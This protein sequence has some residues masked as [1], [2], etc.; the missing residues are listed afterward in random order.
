MPNSSL[1]FK[2]FQFNLP[3]SMS[4]DARR[5]ASILNLFGLVSLIL[6][7]VYGIIGLA[8][9]NTIVA[10]ASFGGVLIVVVAFMLLRAGKVIASAYA[11]SFAIFLVGVTQ[12]Y[13]G[14]ADQYAVAI[15]LL[16]P[17]ITIYSFNIGR[18]VLINISYLLLF[19]LLLY[20]PMFDRVVEYSIVFKL[21]FITSFVAAFI[22]FYVFDYFNNWA[23]TELEKQV[24]LERNINKRKDEFISTLSHQIRTPLNNIMVIANLVDSS[25]EDEKLKDLIDT[26][27][28][29]TNNLVNV[30]NSMVEVSNIDLSER[31]SFTINFNLGAT[32]ANTI[33]LFAHQYSNN[34]QFNL[35][36]DE[37]IPGL[38]GG[39]P[40]KIK[41]VFLNI[42]ES[43]IKTKST[44][45]IKIDILVKK[46]SETAEK[47]DLLFELRSNSPIFIPAG[48]GKNQL[49]TSD[50]IGNAVGS[51]VLADVLDL[52]ITQRLI[53]KNGGKLT[54][55]LNSDS[56]IFSF[57]YTFNKVNDPT[58]PL[59]EVEEHQNNAEV[60]VAPTYVPCEKLICLNQMFCLLRII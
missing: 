10:L 29:S 35:K 1:L 7:A 54:I 38:I 49:I 53:E 20:V 41:Q 12:A 57:P 51:Q 39:E 17:L 31:D 25:T 6:Y 11:L 46:S 8:V 2:I 47:V 13:I 3:K 33:K 37:V 42:I 26:I 5:K 45:R 21:S 27:H 58:A 28:A 36:I 52:K 19:S 18:A 44:S 34:V 50:L 55:V 23:Q 40:V 16:L 9:D 59:K 30:V 15:S 24:L 43:L 48:D 4:D 22:L 60:K 32:V 56:S 14:V